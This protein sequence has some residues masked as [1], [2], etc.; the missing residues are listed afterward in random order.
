[1]ARSIASAGVRSALIRA[2]ELVAQATQ[3]REV[4]LEES[5]DTE[6]Q[7]RSVTPT[8]GNPRE[9]GTETDRRWRALT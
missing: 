7:G 5:P 3:S 9:S 6:G 2:V 8:R 1:M 4:T